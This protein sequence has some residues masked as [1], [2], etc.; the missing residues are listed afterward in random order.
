MVVALYT[1]FEAITNTYTDNVIEKTLI[2][3]L[4]ESSCK[5]RMSDVLTFVIGNEDEIFAFDARSLDID[6]CNWNAIDVQ[7]IL[8]ELNNV[9]KI[10]LSKRR[11]DERNRIHCE[12]IMTMMNTMSR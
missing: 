7:S 8:I 9:K 10:K 5:V 11:D 2:C 4:M 6:R 3:H 12:E 1:F